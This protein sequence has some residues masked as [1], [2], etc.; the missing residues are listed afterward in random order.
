MRME[1]TLLEIKLR[2]NLRQNLLHVLPGCRKSFKHWTLRVAGLAGSVSHLRC[3]G[4]FF[5]Q[6]SSNIL[7]LMN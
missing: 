1:G 4:Q 2:L 3:E 7:F 5:L 6:F